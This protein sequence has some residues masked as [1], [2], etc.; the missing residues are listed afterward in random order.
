MVHNRWTYRAR[1][2]SRF[3]TAQAYRSVSASVAPIG[4][5]YTRSSS[6]PRN[7]H[8]NQRVTTTRWWREKRPL[9]EGAGWTPD[10]TP[11]PSSLLHARA[12]YGA[13][14]ALTAA[15]GDLQQRIRHAVPPSLPLAVRCYGTLV[16]SWSTDAIPSH[17]ANASSSAWTAAVMAR[18]KRTSWWMACTSSF[19]LLRSAVASTLPTS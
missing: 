3:S 8:D 4:G 9:P 12:V 15:A 14:R 5:S 6:N 2:R 16:S 10:L 13:T 18:V 17:D 1:R 11:D 7:A 19:E